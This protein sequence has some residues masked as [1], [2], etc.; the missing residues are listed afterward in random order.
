[1]ETIKRLVRVTIEKD[2]EI[3]MMPGIFEGMTEDEFL[4]EF[5]KGLWEVE[6]IEDVVKYAARMAAE[7]GGGMQHDGIGLLDYSHTTYP[8]VPDVK[9]RILAEEYDEDILTPS[10]D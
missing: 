6:S 9:F 1:M 2:I 10:H 4:V 8:R 7:H 5:R 3:E